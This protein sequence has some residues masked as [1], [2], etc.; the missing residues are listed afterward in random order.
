[1]R[2]ILSERLHETA[3][4]LCCDVAAAAGMIFETELRLLE[5]MRYEL[6]IAR[7]HAASEQPCSPKRF[8]IDL[9]RIGVHMLTFV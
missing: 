4:A 9:N 3:Y 5:E 1:M 7:L 6:N 8:A 2:D